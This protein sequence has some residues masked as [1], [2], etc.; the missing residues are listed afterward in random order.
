VILSSAPPALAFDVDGFRSGMTYE[1]A[2]QVISRMAP[3]HTLFY[4]QTSIVWNTDQNLATS[5]RSVSFQ[6]DGPDGVRRLAVYHKHLPSDFSRFF[7]L[8]KSFRDRLGMPMEVL[9]TPADPAKEYSQDM[10]TMAWR[11]Q[12]EQIAV[13]YRPDFLIIVYTDFSIC[14]DLKRYAP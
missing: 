7:A 8:V 4:E 2:K 5:L 1:E 6:Q 9:A 10:V 12:E 13:K 11:A 14:P 3:Q